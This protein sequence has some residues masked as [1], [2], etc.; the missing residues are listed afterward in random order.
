MKKILS[1]LIAFVCVFA[2]L[3]CGG[4]KTTTT[5]KPNPTTTT[6]KQ[7][8]ETT[9]KDNVTTTDGGSNVTTTDGGSDITTTDGGGEDL[10]EGVKAN[11][12]S[13]KTVSRIEIYEQPTKRYY[14]IGDTFDPAGGIVKVVYKDKTSDLVTLSSS[15]FELKVNDFDTPNTYKIIVKCGRQSENLTVYVKSKDFA[16]TYNLAYEGAP[17]PT[18]VRIVDGDKAIPE[19]PTREGYT[20]AG[21]YA[22]KDYI[23][24][25]DFTAGVTADANLYALWLKDGVEH[26]T[27]TFE[28]GYYGDNYKTYSYQ[29]DAGSPVA[30]PTDPLR[31]GYTFDKWLD[32]AGA[33]YDFSA[34][35]TKDTKLTAAWT[36]AVSGKQYYTFEA[37]DTS[38]DKKVGPAFSGTCSEE[39]MIVPAPKDRACSNGYFVSYLYREG[40][41]LEFVIACD[42]DVSDVTLYLRCSAELRDYTYD[43]SNYAVLLN[44][45]A[46]DYQPI[47][48]TNVPRPEDMSNAA[49]QLDCLTF[50]DYLIGVNLTLK[51]GQNVIQVM[52]MNS[53][54]MDGSTLEAAAPIIDAIKIETTAVL[55]WDHTLNLPRTNQY[56][57][58]NP[59]DY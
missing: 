46:L 6:Q 16:V 1:L 55:Q 33:A 50:Q 42:E 10:P 35:I 26:Y 7:G 39:G 14:L 34:N 52:T 41:S 49:D 43:P 19:T 5:A 59:A 56:S 18:V 45:V 36:K 20:F 21:W 57:P 32:E 58:R 31:E 11:I 9:T 40:N 23:Y 27:V 24:T 2:L 47:V 12:D 22:H 8:G 54:G 25:Y 17:E 51:K 28:K 48:F 4:E 30:R 38:L 13:E 15:S 53:V 37:E 44:D 29:V 3:A